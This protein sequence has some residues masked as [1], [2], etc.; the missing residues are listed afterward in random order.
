MASRI[1]FVALFLNLIFPVS[2]QAATITV[3]P[4]QLIQT[5]VNNATSGDTINVQS[6]TY[7]E[8]ITIAKSNLTL[9]A[10]GSA[11]ITQGFSINNA[12]YVTIKDFEVSGATGSGIGI[13]VLGKNCL[14]ENNY[15]H[16]ASNGGILLKITPTDLAATSDCQ[17]KN[18]RLFQNGRFGIDVRGRNHTIEN[19]EV[20]DTIQPSGGDA[21][22]FHFHGSGH[23]F[24][25]NYI[26]DIKF[27]DT[28]VR[29]AHIDCFQT[30]EVLPYQERA[31]NVTF[32]NNRCIL[33]YYCH[34]STCNTT[35]GQA[36]TK[37]IMAQQA[38]NLTIKNNLFYTYYGIFSDRPVADPRFTILNN[39][40]IGL[41]DQNELQC[42]V[43]S[44]CWPSG[45]VLD[46]AINSVI[47][48]NIFYN[49]LHKVMDLKNSTTGMQIDYNLAYRSD[50][51]TPPGKP[52]SPF[53]QHDLW[54][55][56]PKFANP[57]G[58]DYHLQAGSPA[59]A[60][61]ENGSYIGTFLCESTT[62]SPSPS[63]SAP[64]GKAGDSDG[65]NDVDGVD[66]VVWLNHYNQSV[67]GPTNGDYN[68]S[69]K[70]DGVD[71]VL[72]LNNYGK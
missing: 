50:G 38:S 24:R 31:S 32:E 29:D 39:T 42:S 26:H 72:W 65:D 55:V 41:A 30:F 25:N 66:Y 33:P 54:G 59:C 14:I 49:Q 21:D 68:N 61:G 7:D 16:S 51:T 56:D 48:N 45:I 64:A 18:N 28:T 40:L 15:V 58:G 22:A 3:S 43:G 35:P 62:S 20:W 13:E 57:A 37:G 1:F 71:Y 69:G 70:V 34:S 10:Q 36:V 8:R 23:V 27:N 52:P 44:N 60:G 63:P 46:S 17:V 6:G 4:G 67:S 53:G 19:N 11:I 47:K 9:Q 2:A 12:N 5:A